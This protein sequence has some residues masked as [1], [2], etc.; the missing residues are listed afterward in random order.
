MTTAWLAA[1]T[2]AAA[3][4]HLQAMYQISAVV[5]T[6][7]VIFG[8]VAWAGRKARH[9]GLRVKLFLDDW[10]GSM[11][12]PGHPAIPGVM[13]AIADLRI[14]IND[15]RD[16]TKPDD[17]FSMRDAV[18]RIEADLA[19]HRES[20]AILRVDVAALRERLEVFE[21]A[22]AIRDTERYPADVQHQLEQTQHRQEQLDPLHPEQRPRQE[23]G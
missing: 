6:C 23:P 11:A 7:G 3:S 12:R 1:V 21:N 10:D 14:Q 15:I 20:T 17:G 8:A 22:R 19:S 13:Q 4:G 18:E 16:E 5:A 9:L 2:A